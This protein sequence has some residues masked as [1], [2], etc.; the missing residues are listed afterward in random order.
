[1]TVETRMSVD[2][3]FILRGE[4]H[5]EEPDHSVGFKGFFYAEI[6]QAI[7]SETGQEIQLSEA[8]KSEAE[9]LLCT[10]AEESKRSGRESSQ[11]EA[12]LER[13]AEGGR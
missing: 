10:A 7:D 13:A 2:R 5:E 8:E 4:I 11:V 1:M 9:E 3:E 12:L 6:V